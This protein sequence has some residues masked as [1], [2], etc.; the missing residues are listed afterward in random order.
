[1]ER[2]QLS[3]PSYSALRQNP[4]VISFELPKPPPIP[5]FNYH[6]SKSASNSPPG[7]PPSEIRNYYLNAALQRTHNRFHGNGSHSGTST[8][9][10]HHQQRPSLSVLVPTS[11]YGNGPGPSQRSYSAGHLKPREPEITITSPGGGESHV[12]KLERALSKLAQSQNQSGRERNRRSQVG[13]EGDSIASSVDSSIPTSVEP[14]PPGSPPPGRDDAASSSANLGVLGHERKESDT[15]LNDSLGI[16]AKGFFTKDNNNNSSSSNT[17]NI[18]KEKRKKSTPRMLHRDVAPN[19]TDLSDA[20]PRMNFLMRQPS[21]A[22]VLSN[23]LK[24]HANGRRLDPRLVQA[25]T[26]NQGKPKS[27]PK[28]PT[29]YSQSERESFADV[30]GIPILETTLNL[31]ETGQYNARATLSNFQPNSNR[32]SISLQTSV[33]NSPSFTP[34]GSRRGSIVDIEGDARTDGYS[35][36]GG[37]GSESE[38]NGYGYEHDYGYDELSNEEKMKITNTVADILARQDFIIRL[39]KSMIKYGAPTHRLE[40]SVDHS[41]SLLELNLQCIYMP[42]VMIISFT[43]YETHTSETHLLRVRAGLNMCKN[44]QVHRV[45]TLVAHS[46]MS[47]EEGIMK[48]DAISASANIIPRWLTIF[49]SAMTSFC[50][51]IVFFGGTWIDAAVAFFIGIAVS[52]LVWLSEKVPSYAHICGITMCVTISFIAEATHNT[53]LCIRALKLGG[54]VLL[55]PGYSITCGVLELCSR[56]IITGSVRLFYSVIYSL[57][58]GYGLTLG[59]S[60]W[61]LFDPSAEPS[62]DDP[63]P[64]QCPNEELSIYW[65]FLLAPI[66]S[67]GFSIFLNAHPKQWPTSTILSMIGYATF[68]LISSNLSA[69]VG[70]SAVIAAFALGF[71]ANLYQRLTGQLMFQAVACSIMVMVPGS[72]SVRGVMLIYEDDMTGGV[73]LAIHMILIAI[74][75]SVGLFASTMVVYPKGET[76]SAQMTF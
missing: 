50:A 72:F 56:H 6:D 29:V 9:H 64:L 71:I 28:R 65:S 32:P 62:D 34:L 38:S 43:D 69:P 7:T 66:L 14:T 46:D 20:L 33:V 59:T 25:R 39:A 21:K 11:S 36:Y 12:D 5:R 41:A 42:N 51:A 45:Q 52:L 4:P 57:L 47:I 55:L 27:K 10:H 3:M 75:I 26:R 2:N 53:G 67:I 8:P 22:G 13:S 58:L 44:S 60:L 70:V 31:P 63:I 16:R 74:A 30:R 24:L 19:D 15:T 35:Y 23:L 17:N 54:I 37:D 1:M 18:I 76:K 68:R 49:G 48:L 61:R 73:N 40:N